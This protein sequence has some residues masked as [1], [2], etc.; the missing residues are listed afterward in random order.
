MHLHPLVS[1]WPYAL[2]FWLA[3]VGVYFPEGILTARTGRSPGKQDA[4]SLRLAVAAQF[5]GTG[6]AFAI[7]FSV[8]S[9]SLSHPHFWFWTGLA[10]MVAGSILR[11]HC[12]RM[13]GASF[14]TAVVVVRE[15]AIVQR[16]AYRWVR[17]P[18]YTG[19]LLIYAGIGLALG[20]WISLIVVVAI[21]LA[22]FAYRVRVEEQALLAT[23]GEPY[24][25]YMGRTKRFLP[26]LV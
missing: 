16:G 4:G 3:Y 26:G 25:E 13:L 22:S 9:G 23:L 2:V 1:V 18:S 7:A 12:F 8:R 10:L 17:H 20:N 11:H 5:L 21:V 24:R 14:T 19:A 15:Q 6:V